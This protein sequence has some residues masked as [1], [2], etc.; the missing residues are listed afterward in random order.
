MV[1]QCLQELLIGLHIARASIILWLNLP[2]PNEN[3]KD[4]A[5]R[6]R[7]EPNAARLMFSWDTKL[8][9][10]DE[11]CYDLRWFGGTGGTADW[12]DSL[13]ASSVHGHS[14]PVQLDTEDTQ[15]KS[16]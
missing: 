9:R 5:V 1:H 16:D 12:L 3:L 6:L 13:A 15:G 8:E 10:I 14:R 2:I 7:G 4:R 11:P